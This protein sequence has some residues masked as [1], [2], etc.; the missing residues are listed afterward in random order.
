MQAYGKAL[1]RRCGVV[2]GMATVLLSFVP[3]WFCGA[4]H[5]VGNVK[6]GAA[7]E[8]CGEQLR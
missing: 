5:C 7:V 3:L 8:Q 1:C 2:L 6:D 4:R